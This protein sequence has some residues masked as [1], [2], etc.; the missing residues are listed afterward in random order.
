MTTLVPNAM[1]A[2]DGGSLG[3]R[4]RL[5][6]GS[7]LIDQ[8]NA[9]ASQTFTAGAAIAYCVDRWYASCT[10]AN[11]TGQRVSATAGGY[12]LTGAAS[13]T[14][15]LFGQ[16]IESYNL[17]D[18][19]SA[20]VTAQ[21]KISSTSITSVTWTAYYATVQDTFSTKT[22]I[23]TGTFTINSTPTVYTASFN[24]GA[25]AANGI[26]IEYTTG[27]L[28]AGQTLTYGAAQLEPG[29]TATAVERRPYGLEFGLAQ[30][31]YEIAYASS[32]LA[33]S[34]S[35]TTG[36]PVVF[37]VTKRATPTMSVGTTDQSS[38]LTSGP[39][40]DSPRPEG[41]SFR[42]GG[43]SDFSWWGT[44]IATAEL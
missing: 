21:I 36:S 38:G 31:Y 11:M 22:Q 43:V 19:V 30:R 17:A 44:V 20:T 6:N 27:A 40:F 29:V 35:N 26:A 34:G 3:F 7:F 28:L 25:N 5:I 39:V 16:R 2:F 4:N 42:V 9:G 13:N 32:R 37:K 33:V 41:A 18:Q 10:G 24:A 12:M 23:A 1:L 8:R 14:G 15:T